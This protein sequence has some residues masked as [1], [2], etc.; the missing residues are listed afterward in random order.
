MCFKPFLFHYLLSTITIK[1][2]HYISFIGIELH[3][4]GYNKQPFYEHF[5]LTN[6]IHNSLCILIESGNKKKIKK[7]KKKTH[8]T[9]QKQDIGL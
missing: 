2:L 7:I 3:Q 9:P 6:L 1:H 8:N 4:M 5:M